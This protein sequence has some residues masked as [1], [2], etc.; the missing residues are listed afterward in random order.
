[1]LLDVVCLDRVAAGVDVDVAAGVDDPRCAPRTVGY[2]RSAALETGGVVQIADT[3]PV[4][5][6]RLRSCHRPRPR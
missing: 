1:M 4:L 6:T 2:A 3:V 5:R